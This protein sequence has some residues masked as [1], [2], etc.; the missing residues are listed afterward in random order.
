[1]RCKKCNGI[2]D[3]VLKN[4]PD[5][6]LELTTEEGKFILEHCESNMAMALTILGGPISREG[7]VKIVNLNEQFKTIRNKLIK[8]GVKRDE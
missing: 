2:A 4:S 3:V 8:A 6:L 5:V 1:M 7:A